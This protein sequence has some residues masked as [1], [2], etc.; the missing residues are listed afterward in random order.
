MK[1]RATP[2]DSASP[3]AAARSKSR[4][5]PPGRENKLAGQKPQ[6]ELAGGES[7]AGL[8]SCCQKRTAA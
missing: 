6:R 5:M 4:A 1:A 2:L 3:S 7:V 8:L